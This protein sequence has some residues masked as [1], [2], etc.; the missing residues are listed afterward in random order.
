MRPIEIHAATIGRREV[1][2]V[3]RG[4]VGRYVVQPK[5]RQAAAIHASRFSVDRFEHS[6]VVEYHLSISA[7][8]RLRLHRE[9][10]ELTMKAM[11]VANPQERERLLAEA[12]FLA[13]KADREDWAIQ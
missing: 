4:W 11:E 3:P 8:E 9:A 12:R 7:I 13:E 5:V 2:R 10:A 1:R 6:L